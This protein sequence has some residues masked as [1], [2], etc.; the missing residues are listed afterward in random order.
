[1]SP[2]ANKGGG[3]GNGDKIP[4]GA[5]AVVAVGLLATLAAALLANENLS[6][7]AAGLEWVQTK[8][9]PDSQP[10]EV[11]GGNGETMQLT[12]A[13][14]HATGVNVSGY[15]LFSSGAVLRI[16]AGSPIGSARIQCTMRAPNDTEVGQTTGSRASYPRS[17]EELTEQ[18]VPESG[19][20]VEFSSHGAG[21]AEVELEGLPSQ[22][23]TEKGIKVEWPTYRLGV[24]HWRWYLP[25]G[26][27]GT[28]LVLPFITVWRTTKIPSAE[29]ACTLI[30]SA[31]DASVRTSGA[32]SK[33]SEPIAE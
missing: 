23:A 28:E 11:P 27:P 30:T 2:G 8:K 31:G 17:S 26:P 18:D 9:L 21:F 24:E 15:S 33:L 6:G 20:Q 3:A 25:P 7:E 29:I 5:I 1:V 32:L 14:I 10:V 4:R 13:A 12:Q 16:D 22:F 19:V